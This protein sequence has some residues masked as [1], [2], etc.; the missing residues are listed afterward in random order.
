MSK[1][2]LVSLDESIARDLEY[3]AAESDC[4]ISTVVDDLIKQSGGREGAAIYCYHAHHAPQDDL[5]TEQ[6]PVLP[7]LDALVSED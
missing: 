6:K 7:E 5:D 4:S 2:K 1:E 3:I